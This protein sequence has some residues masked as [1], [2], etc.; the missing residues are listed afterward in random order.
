MFCEDKDSD[1]AKVSRQELEFRFHP[2][3]ALRFS[4]TMLQ[5]RMES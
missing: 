2:Q 1:D 4:Q 3:V 5:L